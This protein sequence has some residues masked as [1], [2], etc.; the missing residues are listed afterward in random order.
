MNKYLHYCVPVVLGTIFGFY[1][2]FN[3]RCKEVKKL[4]DNIYNLTTDNLE[5]T[6]TIEII[7]QVEKNS[8]VDKICQVDKI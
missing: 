5:L 8:K 6:D 4:N 2:G 3:F 1:L 7:C